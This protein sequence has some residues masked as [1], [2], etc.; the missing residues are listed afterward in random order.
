MLLR[1]WKFLKE[2]DQR[3]KRKKRKEK[4]I[5]YSCVWK[6]W[7]DACKRVPKGTRIRK[8]LLSQTLS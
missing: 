2:E 4:D 8:Y 5:D 1:Q 7:N 3:R 6:K